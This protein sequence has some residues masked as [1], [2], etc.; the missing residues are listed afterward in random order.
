VSLIHPDGSGRRTLNTNPVDRDGLAWSPEPARLR[1]TYKAVDVPHSGSSQG[2]AI[3]HAFVKVY[4]LAT[5][6][7]TSVA[8]TSILSGT[9]PAWSPDGTRISWWDDGVKVISV[10]DAMAG[11]ASPLTVLPTVDG[12]CSEHTDLAGKAVCGPARWSPDSRW[13][14]GPGIGG[15]AIVFGR[16]D[17]S[18][19]SH[20][21]VF[22]QP[23][24]LSA[25][26]GWQVAWQAVT[27]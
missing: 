18:E 3:R 5:A 20:S 1:L 27:P 14:F 10:A 13:L 15:T 26:S 2:P 12:G 9:G 11:H 4:D 7:E 6:M 16:S 24:E 25:V 21:I 19:S 8:E 23:V 22:D 17:G